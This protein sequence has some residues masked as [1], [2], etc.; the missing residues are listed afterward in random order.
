[1]DTARRPAG[2]TLA[3]ADT[4][5]YVVLPLMKEFDA[6]HAMYLDSFRRCRR[7]LELRG[8]TAA[9]Y[10][11]VVDRLDSD[12]LFRSSQL[13]RVQLLSGT[14]PTSADAPFLTAVAEYL[15]YPL[16]NRTLA[17]L[18]RVGSPPPSSNWVGLLA[19]RS[20]SRTSSIIPIRLHGRRERSEL[21]ICLSRGFSSTTR[22]SSAPI[23][24]S[25]RRRGGPAPQSRPDL[26]KPHKLD[27]SRQRPI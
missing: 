18:L 20:R 7:I 16:R 24:R 19:T 17:K 23:M 10:Y 5:R 1:M 25:R 15:E 8:D 9:G 3:T 14:S 2:S 27:R 13:T 4:F 26:A 6:L 21:W 22:T 12:T 11:E